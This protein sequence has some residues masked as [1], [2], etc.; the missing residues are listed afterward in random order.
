MIFHPGILAGMKDFNRR[1]RAVTMTGPDLLPGLFHFIFKKR[2][3]FLA[4]GKRA[5]E[6]FHNRMPADDQPRPAASLRFIQF[7]DRR[8]DNAIAQHQLI[9][10]DRRKQMRIFHNLA[11][12]PSY[13][14]VFPTPF[15]FSVLPRFRAKFRSFLPLPLKKQTN[16][17]TTKKK[18][19]LISLSFIFDDVIKRCFLRLQRRLLID[20][21]GPRRKQIG[22][23][24]LRNLS[25]HTASAQR[26]QPAFHQDAV[27]A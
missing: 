21:A 17:P 16:R 11:S 14:P 6:R 26:T 9:E 5:A 23:I 20:H 27:I 15:L 25:D 19:A 2:R 24:H 7:A 22:D 18:G 4:A 8:G 3:R 13:Y 12:F 1:P 10:L